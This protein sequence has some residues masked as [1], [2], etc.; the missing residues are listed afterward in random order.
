LQTSRLANTASSLAVDG[1]GACAW[2]FRAD[3]GWKWYGGDLDWF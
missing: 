1:I 3:D 2:L